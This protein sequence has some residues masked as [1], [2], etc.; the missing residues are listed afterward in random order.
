VA[1]FRWFLVVA[2]AAVAVGAWV[3]H[4]RDGVAGVRAPSSPKYHCPM[5]P[6][7]VADEPGSCPICFMALEP[8]AA[9]P[10]GKPQDDASVPK[11]LVPLALSLDRVQAIGVKTVPV[12]DKVLLPHGRGNGVVEAA[13]AGF[14]QVHVRTPGFVERVYVTDTGATVVRGQPLFAFYSPEILRAQEELLVARQWK[15]ENDSSVL[16]STRTKLE[17]WGMGSREIDVV[18]ATGR[19][20]RSITVA[21]SE[22]GT[23]TRKGL[24]TGAY[25]TPD[26]VLYELQD[27]SRILVVAQ[28]SPQVSAEV[29]RG[30]SAVFRSVKDPN[31]PWP[32]VVDWVYGTSE[33]GTLRV[34]LR[35]R[36][37]TT[38]LRPGEYGSVEFASEPRRGLV[39]PKDAVLHAEGQSYV[40]VD[41]GAGQFD[42]RLVQEEAVGDQE[43]LLRD[44]VALGDAVVAGAAFL[45]DSESRLRAALVEP[46]T[47]QGTSGSDAAPAGDGGKP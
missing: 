15:G 4:L 25:V 29:K 19:V 28:V 3:Q 34:R 44:G 39:V 1:A 20:Q 13:E 18:L 36:E 41:R 26:M 46:P 43:V 24:V 17:L 35:P 47:G 14:S 16:S 40:F 27:L 10:L 6:K 31:R 11:G 9:V 32:F 45:L 7:V 22:A 37:A 8:I 42:V 23:V 33:T 12:V 38:G 5:H 2:S 21:A 30:Q